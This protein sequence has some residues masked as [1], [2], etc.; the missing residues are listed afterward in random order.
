M[1]SNL[2]DKSTSWNAEF[3]TDWSC[4]S[5]YEGY[6]LKWHCCN[7][8]MMASKT[9][10]ATGERIETPHHSKAGGLCLRDVYLY[11][12][13]GVVY[14]QVAVKMSSLTTN[15]QWDSRCTS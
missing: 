9:V 3:V 14:V 13:T 7:P 15:I 5:W 4:L 2:E 6:Q 1:W 10:P 8:D 11:W 12:Q